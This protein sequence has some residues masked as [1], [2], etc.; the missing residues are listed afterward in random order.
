MTDRARHGDAL[1]RRAGK[2]PEDDH[3]LD[4]PTAADPSDYA[5]SRVAQPGEDPPGETAMEP[6]PDDR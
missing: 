3:P 5:D 2:A 4:Q 6:I 1:D